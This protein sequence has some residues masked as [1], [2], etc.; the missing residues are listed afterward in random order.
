MTKNHYFNV[1]CKDEP[2]PYFWN[3]FQI[4]Y[5]TFRGFGGLNILYGSSL[6]SN[7]IFETV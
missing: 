2:K 4:R 6:I 3:I 1:L 7:L 5:P